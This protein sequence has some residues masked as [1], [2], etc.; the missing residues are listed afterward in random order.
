MNGGLFPMLQ[1]E[2]VEELELSE[3]AEE[4]GEL[5]RYTLAGYVGGL[6]LGGLLDYLGFQQSE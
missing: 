6:V 2:E 3:E 5:V 4:F 1:G